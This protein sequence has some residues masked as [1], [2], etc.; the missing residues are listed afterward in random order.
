MW[1]K[2]A[3]PLERSKLVAISFAGDLLLKMHSIQSTSTFTVGSYMGTAFSMTLSGLLC[4]SGFRSPPHQSK[5]PSVFYVF[6]QPIHLF[7]FLLA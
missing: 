7:Y 3:P 4:E 6:G 1:R 5:W 2:W